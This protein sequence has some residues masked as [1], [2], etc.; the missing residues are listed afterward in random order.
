MAER[1]Q[2]VP[3]PGVRPDSLGEYL[4]GLGLLAAVSR[5]WP[6]TRGCWR[7]GEFVLA[8]TGLNADEVLKFLEHEW[9][10][11]KYERWWNKTEE[12]SSQRSWASLNRVKLLD[13]HMV[14]RGKRRVNNPVLGD[15]GVVGQRDF[16]QVAST[17]NQLRSTPQSRNWLEHTIL[18]RCDV[19]LP[20]LSST[21]TWF[22]H[23]NKT[24]NSGQ[25][26]SREGQLSPWSYLL[27]LEG[28]LLLTGSVNKRLNIVAR[29]Y[30]AF[31]FVAEA[32]APDNASELG[33]ARAEF[34]GP[35]WGNPATIIELKD[36]LQRG[37]A[38]VGFRAARTPADFAVA[39][40]TA[41]A[42]SGLLGFSR[43]VLRRTT[44]EKYRESIGAGRV[45]I[46]EGLD[47]ALA[48]QQI[49]DW[50]DGLPRDEA[51]Q[52]TK[53][54]AGLKGPV[55][56]ALVALAEHPHEAE[57]WQRLLLV[58]ADVQLRMDRNRG[59]RTGSPVLEKLD[60]S[61][62]RRGWRAAGSATTPASLPAEVARCIAGLRS[63]PYPVFHNIFGVAQG[64]RKFGKESTAAAVWSSGN[65][66]SVLAD[67]LERRLVD[68]GRREGSDVGGP[69]SKTGPPSPLARAEWVEEFLSG[70]VDADEVAR[71][72]PAF[73]MVDWTAGW[74]REGPGA[75]PV[76]SAEYRLQALFRPLLQTDRIR[77][78]SKEC[79]ASLEPKVARA[80]AV[81]AAI[82]G[83]N[84]DRALE[85]A[86]QT[87]RSLNL[88]IVQLP[89]VA[90][91]GDRIVAAVLIPLPVATVRAE[92][93]R[94]WLTPANED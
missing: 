46:G 16:A 73:S 84:W 44:T 85:I 66:Y 15:A 21:A 33:V 86:E 89:D 19:S 55:E 80:R 40:L 25:T 18:G 42:Q 53:R 17:C 94:I 77:L 61:L 43:F 47:E 4:V 70:G 12:I 54:F 23:A 28:A 88:R 51:S 41:G 64:D 48:L 87:Y 76:A 62:W 65:G 9:Q 63:G 83:G 8:G 93:R 57:S 92:F 2:V 6:C 60:E 20:S 13:C 90:A 74:D 68:S 35:M 38:R 29:P 10:P 7:G 69:R 11:T 58:V 5:K 26:R 75:R 45:E 30:G 50:A 24:F 59:L 79:E 91:E 37:L 31:P 22:V 34:W 71:L 56:R 32:P 78:T 3:C 67:I 49:A 81:L 14:E 1:L 39:A 36:L 52:K 27:A 72:L 82:R